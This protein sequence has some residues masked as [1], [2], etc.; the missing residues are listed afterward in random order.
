ML[1]LVM[2][3]LLQFWELCALV[4]FDCWTDWVNEPK[5]YRFCYLGLSALY[6]AGRFGACH[7]MLHTL[8]GAVYLAL[9]LV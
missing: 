7:T 2:T 9:Y 8:G 5:P 4:A 6:F 1:D 3:A